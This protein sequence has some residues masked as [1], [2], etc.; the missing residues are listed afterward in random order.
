MRGA[1]ES[2]I[3][4]FDNKFHRRP[5][6]SWTRK[7]RIYNLHK[8]RSIML[9][10]QRNIKNKIFH[11]NTTFFNSTKLHKLNNYCK[12]LLQLHSYWKIPTWILH[13]DILQ[14][15]TWYSHLKKRE[16]VWQEVITI[17]VKSIVTIKFVILFLFLLSWS[18]QSLKHWRW[19]KTSRNYTKF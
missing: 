9:L 6:S 4:A 3:Q 19:H 16:I 8:T 10:L 18:V 2:L 7:G 14:L 12:Y 17:N 13:D 15:I 5:P 1:W 11:Q